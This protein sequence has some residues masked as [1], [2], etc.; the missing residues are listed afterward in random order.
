MEQP[1]PEPTLISI[2]EGCLGCKWTLHVLAQIRS[3]VNRPGALE[4]SAEGLTAK[5]LS[6]RLVKLVGFGILEKR[7]FA[8]VP[9]RVEYHFTAFGLRVAE[10]IDELEQIRREYA[11]PGAI[12][13]PSAD[14]HESSHQTG[15]VA[16]APAPHS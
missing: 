14:S 6:E 3:G 4:R 1:L 9:P 10:V 11:K 12:L 8:E 15:I 2:V 7:T 16:H 13:Q 5:V